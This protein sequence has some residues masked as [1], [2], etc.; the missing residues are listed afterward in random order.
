[1]N[2]R[3]TKQEL[4]KIEEVIEEISS[5]N[6]IL[7][8]SNSFE[9]KTLEINER[10]LNAQIVILENSYRASK[11]AEGHLRLVSSNIF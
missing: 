1:M 3:L 8:P 11:I 7:D 6:E 10:I 9:A 4:L 5:Q 2:N